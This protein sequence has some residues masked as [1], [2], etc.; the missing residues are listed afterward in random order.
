[1]SRAHLGSSLLH[2]AETTKILKTGFSLFQPCAL[3]AKRLGSQ[4]IESRSPGQTST[5]QD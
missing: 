1:M 2:K 5:A 4:P 3:G